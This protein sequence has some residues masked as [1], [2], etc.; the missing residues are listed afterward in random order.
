MTQ[1]L[2]MRSL[3]Y[4]IFVFLS[5]WRQVSYLNL[6]WLIFYFYLG[7][8]VDLSC[9]CEFHH[10]TNWFKLVFNCRWISDIFGHGQI[11]TNDCFFPDSFSAKEDYF[12]VSLIFSEDNWWGRAPMAYLFSWWVLRRFNLLCHI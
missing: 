4:S 12:R 2:H 9:L 6:V 7:L 5:E 11:C 10:Y 1:E 3:P 8:H